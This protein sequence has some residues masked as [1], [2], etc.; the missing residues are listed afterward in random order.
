MGEKL[1]SYRKGIPLVILIVVAVVVIVF[2]GSIWSLFLVSIKPGMVGIV[3]NERGEP[4]PA[5]HFV[6]EEGYKGIQREVLE[7][8]LHFFWKTTAFMQIEQ[9]PMTVIPEGKVGVLVAQDGRPLPEGA[10]LAEDDN[11]DEDGKLIK[12]GQKGIRKKLIEPGTHLI[13]TKYFKIEQLD[14]L[15]IPAGKVGVL[16]RKI[17]DPP[18]EGEILVSMQSNY[19]GFVREVLEPG[20][21]YLHPRI[22]L[23]DCRCPQCSGRESRRAHQKDRRS[24]AWR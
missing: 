3:F 23:G 5:G 18:P 22:S 21:R 15:N 19:R 7:P 17:G 14:A 20:I 13:N 9:V 4:D 24:P 10:V 8:G 11:F 12:I 2:I 1:A 16:T 6:V